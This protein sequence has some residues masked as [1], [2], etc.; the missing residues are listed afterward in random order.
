MKKIRWGIIG[1]GFIANKFALAVR[2]AEGAELAAVAS[3]KYETA[4]AFADKYGIGNVFS[5]YED[6]AAFDGIDAVYIAVP[7]S[8]HARYSKMFINAGKSILCEKPI[9]VNSKELHE[10][11]ELAKEK[12]VF[13]ME[14]MWTRF[15][16]VMAEVKRL[17]GEGV[18]GNVKEVS[19]DFCYNEPDRSQIMFHPEN[20][21]GSLLDVGVYG[22]NLASMFLG[23]EIADI[24]ATAYVADGIDERTS[25]LL[26]YKNGTIARI[27]SAL[28]LRKPEDGYIYGDKGYI[29]IPTFYGATEF[30]LS[31]DG[32]DGVTK[33]SVPYKGN[34]FEEEIEE[35]CRCIAEGKNESDIMPLSASA[36][37]MSVMDEARKQIGVAYSADQL[38]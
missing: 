30:E 26:T 1:T 15:L 27:S 6:L 9:T 10:V 11:R 22:I 12:G 37:V 31:L 36:S 4:K 2:N 7:H 38:K 20:A 17:I 32:A 14:A 5:S 28:T 18:I 23:D 8:Y 24:K 16:P 33:H 29:R 25:V 13:V 35:C 3:R 21:G 34:G 19:A